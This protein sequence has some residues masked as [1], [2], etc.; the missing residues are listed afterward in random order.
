MAFSLIDDS[1]GAISMVGLTKDRLPAWL[2][3][4]P[5]RERN[6]LT[7]TGFG[8]TAGKLALVPGENGRLARAVVGFGASGETGAGMWALAGLPDTLPEG[9]YRLETVPEGTDPTHL[10]LGWA[11]ATY[12]FTRYR[13]KKA[14]ATALVIA[15]EP[16]SRARARSAMSIGAAG[17]ARR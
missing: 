10:A 15:C 8:A 11:L 4:A 14:T 7:A 17:P 12:A 2:A 6:W 13:A 9:S 1:A 5:E 3:E 16:A